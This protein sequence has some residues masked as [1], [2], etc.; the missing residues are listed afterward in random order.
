MVYTTTILLLAVVIALNLT[1]I[2]VR[3]KLRRKYQ[4]SAF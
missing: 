1:A 2:V 3:N 4:T